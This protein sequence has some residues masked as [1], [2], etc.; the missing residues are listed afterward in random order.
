MNKNILDSYGLANGLKNFFIPNHNVVIDEK[1]EIIRITVQQST[2]TPG[3]KT[4]VISVDITK[5]YKLSLTG[6][7]ESETCAFV[8]ISN[9]SDF[10]N[11]A[12]PVYLKTVNR[13]IEIEFTPTHENIQIFIVVYK[14]KSGQLFYISN[15][16]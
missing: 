5:R 15:I 6:Y 2:N 3:V 12:T 16:L 4:P 11:I 1:P 13:E 10:K 8:T 9:N 14:P 7:T